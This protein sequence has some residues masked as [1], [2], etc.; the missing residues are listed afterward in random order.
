MCHYL[1]LWKHLKNSSLIAWSLPLAFFKYEKS[2]K[3]DAGNGY[4]ISLHAVEGKMDRELFFWQNKIIG[5]SRMDVKWTPPFYVSIA[6]MDRLR[7]KMTQPKQVMFKVEFIVSCCNCTSICQLVFSAWI[8]D[9][10]TKSVV[11]AYRLYINRIIPHRGRRFTY[12]DKDSKKINGKL[13][14]TPTF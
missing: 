4:G 11:I 9:T 8:C 14:R 12:S 10:F 1:T 2:E 13:D 7:N 6:P 5:S 3:L